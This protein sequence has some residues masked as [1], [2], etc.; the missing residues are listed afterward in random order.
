MG[1]LGTKTNNT[2]PQEYEKA[3]R[4]LGFFIFGIMDFMQKIPL[5]RKELIADRTMAFY[6]AKPEGF[7][8]IPGQTIDITLIDSPETD[9]EGSS[10]TFSI[11]SAPH[12]KELMIAVRMRDTAFKRVLGALQEGAEVLLDGP[13]GSFTLHENTN[14]RAVFIAG[15][16]GVTPFRSIITH[17]T[18]VNLPHEIVLFHVNR[19][20]EDAAFLSE[21]RT[22][23]HMYVPLMTQMKDSVHV[24]EGEEGYLNPLHIKKY[25]PENANAIFYLAGPQPMI[26]A[27]RTMLRDAGISNDDIRYEEFAGY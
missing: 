25:V 18:A 5:L 24:W 23:N 27:V 6:F 7:T 11:A 4:T 1:V 12:E 13:F 10:R 9:I 8:F 16:I 14:R 20:P 17:A 3:E 21:L 26:Y 15:G 22:G 2:F 19:R